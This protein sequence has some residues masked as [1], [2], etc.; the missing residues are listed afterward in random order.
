P[1]MK[2]KK[3]R[4]KK[5]PGFLDRYT[6]PLF[7]ILFASLC[8]V[9]AGAEGWNDIQEYTEGHHDW[10]LKQGMFKEGF[11]VDDTFARIISRINPEQ[12]NLC[13]INWMRSVHEL[14]QSELVAI[15]GKVLRGSCSPEERLSSLHL[16]SAYAT[17]NQLV[18]G[19]VRTQKKSNEITAIPELIKLLDLKGARV[20]IDAMGC[21][22]QI[23]QELLDAGAD[24]LFSVKDNQKHLHRAVQKVLEAQRIAPSVREKIILE[25]AHGRLELRENHV[26]SRR[27]TSS[28]ISRLAGIK[29]TRCCHRLPARKRSIAKSG[30]SLL[31]Q[32]SPIDRR[33]FR[34]GSTQALAY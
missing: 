9:I 8:A 28:G 13:F 18:M 12:F 7:D 30:V 24:Y 5:C 11:P 3:K 16:V 26:I 25:Q 2:N 29:N 10:F 22:T 4:L 17:T 33:K 1:F 27:Y 19:Q 20:S 6:Y 32:L 34:T 21:Q 14:T 15:D 31:H 23:A